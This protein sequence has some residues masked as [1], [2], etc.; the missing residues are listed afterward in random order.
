[1]LVMAS[2]RGQIKKHL[3]NWNSRKQI[4]LASRKDIGTAWTIADDGLP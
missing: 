4:V 3:A 2:L 1:M